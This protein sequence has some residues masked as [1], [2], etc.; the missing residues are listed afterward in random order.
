[1]IAKPED[2]ATV[3]LLRNP[4]SINQKGFEVLM[5]RRHKQN[6]FVPDAYVFPGGRLDA[7]D[8][9]SDMASFCRDISA[10]EAFH[11]LENSESPEKALG[12]WVAGIRETFEEV[13]ILIARRKDG[14]F[15]LPSSPAEA[16]RFGAHRQD[17]IRGI[18]FWQ[19]ILAEEELTL[20][21]DELHYF[22]HWI[23]PEF[24]PLR[25]DVRFF[26]S[27]TPEGQEALPDGIELTNHVWRTPQA[28]L[29]DFHQGQFDMV[30][31]TLMTIESLC[32]YSTI[33]EAIR[34]THKKEITG[35]L[36]TMVEEDGKIIEYTPDGKA[37]KN[38]PPSV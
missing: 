8:C 14:S 33:E 3:I 4:T 25:Y 29:A 21:L 19:Q 32:H 28:I 7:G 12:S 16:A 38:L 34:S 37:Y 9:S 24:L 1:M 10:R 11:I 35:I 2:A 30:L 18:R 27:Q 6:L 15:F 17:L 20:A 36:T 22:S 13:G 31:P 5:V 23:T 26:L